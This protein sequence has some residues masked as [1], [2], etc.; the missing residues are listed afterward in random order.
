MAFISCKKCGC[1]MS[2]K[3]EAC[4]I[5]GTPVD[6][7]PDSKSTEEQ[8]ASGKTNETL[9][10]E[11][12]ET[13]QPL[14]E[15]IIQPITGKEKKN[16]KALI[17]GITAAVILIG[18]ITLASIVTPKKR[19]K[20]QEEPETNNPIAEQTVQPEQPQQ[21]FITKRGCVPFV[22]GASIHG[23]PLHGDYY[24]NV[25]FEQIY[26]ASNG[27]HIAEFKESEWKEFYDSYGEQVE[28]FWYYGNCLVLNG[29]DSIL[30][31]TYDQNDVIDGLCIYSK[32]LQL[33]NG[34]H[35][36]MS[37]ATMAS[38]YN[39]S[40]FS[41]DCFQGEYAMWYSVNGLPDEITLMA[42]RILDIFDNNWPAEPK[43]GVKLYETDYG[44][45]FR[46]PIDEVKD[47]YLKTIVV[48]KEVNPICH[49]QNNNPAE[50]TKKSYVV[51]DASQ[52]RLRIGP[53]LNSDTYKW[54]D[55]TNRHPYIGERFLY[56]GE[57]GDFYQIDF[58]G[59]KLW[60]SKQ[61]T[62]VEAGG[63]T[64]NPN[65]VVIKK[66][67]LEIN[68]ESDEKEKEAFEQKIFDVVEEMPAF[69]G[70]EAKLMEYV[71]KN[72]KYPQIAR[73]TGIQGRVFVGFVVEPDGSISN[74]KLLR[75]LG[76]GCDEEAVRIVKSMPKWK[77]GK[78][79]GKLVRVSYTLPV[80]FRLG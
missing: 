48:N 10:N 17:I 28:D 5:C 36:G 37:S 63:Q 11:S 1:Q 45:V 6:M 31:A 50:N 58:K 68:G 8:G 73:E 65:T 54:P 74:V 12:P 3:S 46:V 33:E 52:L 13:A 7:Y 16:P 39:A 53:S 22:I 38:T 56:L 42:E 59:E 2:D 18:A 70:G 78:Q 29:N 32:E 61:Y 9:D 26:V 41:T 47:S 14:P 15:S 23:I 71:A 76:G 62:H 64:N 24:D 57:S 21:P 34:I 75:G 30:I 25:I 40:F 72:I 49:P 79:H 69:P 67:Q 19:E 44:P 35:V 27:E 80:L 60:V 43:R 55:G 51:I 77:P 4:P 66:E 20:K